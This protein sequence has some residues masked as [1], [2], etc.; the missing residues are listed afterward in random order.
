MKYI[1]YRKGYKYQLAEDYQ[2]AVSI[3]G[4]T[5]VQP[6]FVLDIHGNLLVKAGYAW[7]GPSG[8]TVD[9]ASSMRCS[10]VHDVLYQMLRM[11]LIEQ[12][13]REIADSELYRLAIEDG[14]WTWRAKLWL[15]ELRKFAGGA[16]DPK[17][18]KR[19]YIAPKKKKK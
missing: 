11:K 13:Y 1:A 14:M 5:V 2:G 4:K 10:L 9:T 19:V 15:R 17:N 3:I 18:I 7:D 16:A 8:P 12:H 6:F